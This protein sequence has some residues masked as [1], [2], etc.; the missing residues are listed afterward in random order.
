M[1]NQIKKRL[2]YEAPDVLLVRMD[3]ACSLM[4]T[5]ITV[6]TEGGTAIP[7]VEIIDFNW[8]SGL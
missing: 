3:T 1:N 8:T 4:Q 5:S 7:D 6:P 2:A